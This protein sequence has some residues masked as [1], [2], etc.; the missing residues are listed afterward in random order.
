LI[1]TPDAA[2]GPVAARLARL[3]SWRGKIVLH[4]SGALA[5]SV[6]APLK[7]RGAATGSFHP[8]Q[9]FGRRAA[10]ELSG[11][12]FAIEGDPRACR[13][14]TRMARSLGGSAVA[15][16]PDSKAAYHAAGVF[17]APHLLAVIE[18]AARI[19]MAAGFGRRRAVRALLPLARETL[20]NW[21]RL[22]PRAAWTGP[23]ARADLAVVESHLRALRRLPREYRAAYAA[24][25]RLE[26]RALARRPEGFLRRLAPLLA[27]SSE[28]R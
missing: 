28:N 16:G 2:I 22:G 8:L 12:T 9:T 18:A 15:I 21:E 17:A 11:V 23:I 10:P 14:A 19:L 25:A 27:R 7:R 4:T 20:R 6:L 13:V 26:A 3:G 5:A 1:A 24:L